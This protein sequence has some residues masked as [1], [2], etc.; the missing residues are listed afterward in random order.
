MGQLIPPSALS[1]CCPEAGCCP[2]A[3]AT[4]HHA[5]RART[6]AAILARADRVVVRSDV[7]VRFDIAAFL[8]LV[9]ARLADGAQS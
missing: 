5:V 3:R 2:E 8:L 4:P 1:E 7:R 9:V 6:T